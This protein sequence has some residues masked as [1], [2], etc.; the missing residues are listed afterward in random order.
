M[1]S[2]VCTTALRDVASTNPLTNPPTHQPTNPNPPTLYIGITYVFITMMGPFL[3]FLGFPFLFFFFLFF[4]LRLRLRLVSS[5]LLSSFFFFF[6]S[7]L[8]ATSFA[9][10]AGH[11]TGTGTSLPGS[12]STCCGTTPSSGSSTGVPTPRGSRRPGDSSSSGCRSC[13]ATSQSG[14]LRGFRRK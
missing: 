13:T 8:S 6:F 11:L 3:G 2:S 14:C 4:C 1:P 12:G 10:P 9:I 7:R 5:P